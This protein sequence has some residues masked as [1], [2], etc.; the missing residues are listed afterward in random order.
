M[1]PLRHL[2]DRF[3]PGVELHSLGPR[4]RV[5]DDIDVGV[6][7]S[8]QLD[9]TR[10]AQRLGQH[11][12]LAFG[13]RGG[14]T[15]GGGFL[16]ELTSDGPKPLFPSFLRFPSRGCLSCGF[17]AFGLLSR[18][19]ATRRLLTSRFSPLRLQLGGRLS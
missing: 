14:V 17:L 4:L 13:S 7:A 18:G 10:G 11:V 16:I 19:F 8:E 15:P 6:G 5:T 3:D 2:A 9:S 12:G 1:R